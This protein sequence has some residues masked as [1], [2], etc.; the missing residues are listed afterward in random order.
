MHLIVFDLA[1][2]DGAAVNVATNSLPNS[3]LLRSFVLD[4]TRRPILDGSGRDNHLGGLAG[5]LR[6]AHEQ[7]EGRRLAQLVSLVSLLLVQALRL[8]LWRDKLWNHVS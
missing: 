3:I 5:P 7:F 1:Q 6:A 2:T 8:V 4:F